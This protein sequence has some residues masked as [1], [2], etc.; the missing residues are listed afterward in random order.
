MDD[1]AK[2]DKMWWVDKCGKLITDVILF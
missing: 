2:N 1:G